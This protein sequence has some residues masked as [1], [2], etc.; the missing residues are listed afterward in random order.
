M[1]GEVIGLLVAIIGCVMI[2]LDPNAQKVDASFTR[3]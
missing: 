1:K 2:M 3:T